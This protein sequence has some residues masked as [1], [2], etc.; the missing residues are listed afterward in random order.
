MSGATTDPRRDADILDAVQACDLL[1][2]SEPV[3]RDAMRRQGLPYRRI[4]AKVLRFSRAAL[5]AW[6]AAGGA[7]DDL[8]D[9]EAHS[10][11]HG[12]FPETGSYGRQTGPMTSLEITSSGRRHRILGK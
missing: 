11:A 1:G 5:I 9:D 8:R 4:G 6:V 2:V 3:L 7:D 12:V 10:R